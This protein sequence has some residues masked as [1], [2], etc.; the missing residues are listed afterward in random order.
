MRPPP[1]ICYTSAREK[2]FEK[3]D[4]SR[5]LDFLP[6]AHFKLFNA[7]GNS[8]RMAVIGLKGSAW[9]SLSIE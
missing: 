3:V 6:G 1:V 2:K 7:T 8:L 4:F 5:F 9:L